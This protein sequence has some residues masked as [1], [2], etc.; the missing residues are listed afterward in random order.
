MK[1]TLPVSMVYPYDFREVEASILFGLAPHLASIGTFAI[2][3]DPQETGCWNVTD[4]ETG[5]WISRDRNRDAAIKKAKRQ[6]A[7][8]TPETLDA[9]RDRALK[10]D[11]YRHL[12]KRGL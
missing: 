5:L 10:L 11:A 8:E 12:R 7:R 4:V 1:I 9:A 6:L 3:V 2:H